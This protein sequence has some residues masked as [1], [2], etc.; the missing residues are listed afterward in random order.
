MRIPKINK[1]TNFI[2]LKSSVCG[3]ESYWHNY[4][5][6]EQYVQW[7]YLM[8]NYRYLKLSFSFLDTSQQFSFLL[9]I[10]CLNAH[11]RDT[12]TPERCKGDRRER[13][14]GQKRHQNEGRFEASQ[15][16]WLK[17]TVE[18]SRLQVCGCDDRRTLG[19][20][21]HNT[22]RHQ[23]NQTSMGETSELC[24]ADEGTVSDGKRPIQQLTTAIPT[25][26]PLAPLFQSY[27]L[28]LSCTLISSLTP[29]DCRRLFIFA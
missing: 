8:C 1:T 4:V 9:S 25:A 20:N 18:A 24:R 7:L 27:F 21:S 19:F 5:K 6:C 14:R 10:T 28:S 13:S 29:T 12:I 2:V 22:W 17:W 23:I 15:V 11:H 16:N 26:Y 3:G